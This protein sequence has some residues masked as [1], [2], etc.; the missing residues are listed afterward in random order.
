MSWSHYVFQFD[1]VESVNIN[2]IYLQIVEI[3][4]N[5][6]NVFKSNALPSA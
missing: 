3:W 2:P 1:L 4:N 5:N 6:K